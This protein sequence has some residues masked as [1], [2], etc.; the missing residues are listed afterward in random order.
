MHSRFCF[1][2]LAQVSSI[3]LTA[4]QE[5]D[6]AAAD[7]AKLRIELS[8]AQERAVAAETDNKTLQ[9]ALDVAANDVNELRGTRCP[10]SL[11]PLCITS[12]LTF[13]CF[14]VSR[15]CHPLTAIK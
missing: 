7:V 5:R 1:L 13:I 3:Y 4:Q 11:P 2:A 15:Y 8:E 14:R 10:V 9:N 6:A 12:M